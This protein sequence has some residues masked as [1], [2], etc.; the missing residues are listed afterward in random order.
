MFT[1]SHCHFY[2]AKETPE[3]WLNAAAEHEVTRFLNVSVDVETFH[4]VL[5]L[6]RE[7]DPMWASAGIH[8]NT[9]W[10]GDQ[11]P[12]VDALCRMADDANIIAIGETGLDYF[13]GTDADKPHQFDR[14][15]RH[16]RAARSIGKPLI[17]HCRDAKEDVIRLLREEHAED[18]GGVMHCFVD[19]W[20]TAQQA[21]DLGF[22]ISFS[23][24]VTFKS[25]TDLQAV[26]R[27][28]PLDRMLIETDAPY[29]APVPKRGKPNQPAYVRHVAEFLARM[30]EMELSDLATRTSGNF[31]RLFRV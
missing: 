31:D 28:V 27:Q 22:Y 7:H 30:R 20:E 16:I 2:L 9:P 17:I 15:R 1:D 4:Q 25:A 23:G 14:F 18:A 3:A 10:G 21:M 13:H 8:P 24:I 29:L 26:A 11:E 5:G 19:D 12:D 6:A